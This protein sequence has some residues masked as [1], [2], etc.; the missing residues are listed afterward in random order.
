LN[1]R[2]VITHQVIGFLAIQKK[3]HESLDLCRDF[4]YYFTMEKCALL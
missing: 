1:E 3:L 2:A 4:R